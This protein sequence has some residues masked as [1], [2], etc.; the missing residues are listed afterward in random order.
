MRQTIGGLC[1]ALLHLLRRGEQDAPEEPATRKL[2][3]RAERDAARFLQ[4]LGYRVLERNFNCREGEI[5]LVVFRKGVVAFVE[6]RARTE[7]VDI[8]PLYTVT[9]RKQQRV[10]RAAHRYATVN[11]LRRENVT[12]RFDV[13][14]V[15]YERDGSPGPIEHIENAFTA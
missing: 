4:Q 10:I 5:D 12:M 3:R 1:N 9:R 11:N 7:P 14:A 2:G 6:V 13:I 15:R 8:D